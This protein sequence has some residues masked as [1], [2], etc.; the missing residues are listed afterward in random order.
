MPCEEQ[1][2]VS[3]DRTGPFARHVAQ[4]SCRQLMVA[5][6][7][8]KETVMRTSIRFLVSGDDM[9]VVGCIVV[10]ALFSFPGCHPADGIQ[11]DIPSCVLREADV[12]NSVGM[13]FRLIPAGEVRA[14]SNEEEPYREE[15]LKKARAAD[16]YQS[17]LNWREAVRVV[18]IDKPFYCG[19]TEVTQRQ[20]HMF[21]AGRPGR[22]PEMMPVPAALGESGHVIT[23]KE[24][25]IELNNALSR[26]DHPVAGVSW[27]NA[28][29]FCEWLSKLPAEKAEGKSYR[30]PTEEEWEYACRAGS[31]ARY[32]WGEDDEVAHRFCN[33][34]DKS[35]A[36]V[37]FD[38]D[39]FKEP[40][41]GYAVTAPVAS[42]R[43]NEFGLYDMIGNV[44]E[45]CASAFPEAG[46][47]EAK[48]P[49]EGAIIRGGS[50]NQWRPGTRCATRL[51][52]GKLKKEYDVGFR[53]VLV[54][55]KQE[56]GEQSREQ[57]PKR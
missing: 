46:S 20:F 27:E 14:G 57:L 23:E 24:R 34:A 42:F 25:R 30:L 32:P 4:G 48:G 51:G 55:K 7:E 1:K 53:V 12:V 54:M 18:R 2:Y 49:S 8:G 44:W 6:E 26:D 43:P 29:A 37:W 41:D 45:L 11:T 22:L 15:W 36:L 28:V 31:Q 17:A 52:I 3:T 38:P 40:P 10:L 9:K 13:P 16:H 50:W 35:M 47:G 56:H 39:A 5:A 19:M 33:R 21:M